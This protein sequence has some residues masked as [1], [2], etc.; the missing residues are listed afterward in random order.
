MVAARFLP[1]WAGLV[2]RPRP[3]SRP[4]RGLQFTRCAMGNA[5]S[6]I[7]FEAL[8]VSGRT[9]RG[10]AD[11]AEVRELRD[12]AERDLS[13]DDPALRAIYDFAAEC[14]AHRFDQ[15]ALERIGAELNDQI[16]KLAMPTPPGQDRRDING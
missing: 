11:L 13:Q 9:R 10:D 14:E 2:A 12:R 16:G 8:D 4:G 7:L 5:R 15:V 1:V 6:A 3:P